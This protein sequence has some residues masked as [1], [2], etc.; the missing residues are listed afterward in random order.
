[1]SA[2]PP[3]DLPPPDELTVGDIL[4]S[5]R[6]LTVGQAVTLVSVILAILGG[7]FGFGMKV[8]DWMKPPSIPAS[9]P[10]VSQEPAH[11][12][13]I[14]CSE[15]SGWPRGRWYLWGRFR[16][17]K[18]TRPN[19]DNYSRIPQV[20]YYAD[21]VSPS[22]FHSQSEEGAA[23]QAT[24][25]GKRQLI[26]KAKNGQHLETGKTVEF[27]GHDRTGYTLSE[28]LKVS[29]DGCMIIG[30]WHDNRKN[31]GDEHYLYQS[32][33]YYILPR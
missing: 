9:P 10:V 17:Q 8:A 3:N 7:A 21:F 5:L 11:V 29:D 12:G 15:V 26:S 1:M 6:R 18:V 31:E 27:E 4:R 22:E 20:F 33:R 2:Q 16:N 25:P 19:S 13:P 23:T 32:D 30:D 14:P 28:S 24:D